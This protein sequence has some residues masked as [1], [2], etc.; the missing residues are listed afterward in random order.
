MTVQA[1]A[2]TPVPLRLVRGLRAGLDRAGRL[3]AYIAGWNYI[4][5]A[6]F[7]ISDILGRTLF[8]VSSVATVEITGYMLACGISWS[9]AHTLAARAHIRV[10]VLVS[11]LPL[12]PRATLHVLALLLLG[13]FAAFLAWAGWSLLDESLLFD[14][15]DNSALHI[16]LALPQ[17]IWTFGLLAFLLMITALLLEAVLTLLC[18]RFKEAD[19]LLGSRSIDDDASEALEAVAMARKGQAA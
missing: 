3:M 12:R 14:A 4:L 7:I 2:S 15:H 10:D 8:G 9:L 1:E 17:G 11:R 19:A 18:G 5:C 16:P 6:L 13:S